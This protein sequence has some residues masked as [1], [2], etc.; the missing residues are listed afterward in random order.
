MQG[1]VKPHWRLIKEQPGCIQGAP[2]THHLQGALEAKPR[3][4]T[5]AGHL[6]A[7]SSKAQACKENVSHSY[8]G[9]HNQ[10]SPIQG[11]P[12]NK[13]A[14]SQLPPRQLQ[15]SSC[16]RLPT[17]YP[18]QHRLLE[19]CWGEATGISMFDCSAACNLDGERWVGFSGLIN[20]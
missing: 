18:P 5:A 17:P 16:Q 20:T 7:P 11:S 14:A 10:S 1:A 15:E 2:K 4:K 6:E 13:Q 8:A 19:C 9:L 12:R 3:H